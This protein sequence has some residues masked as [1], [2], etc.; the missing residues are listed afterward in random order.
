MTTIDI[1]TI[2][3]TFGYDDNNNFNNNN[4]NQFYMRSSSNTAYMLLYRKIDPSRNIS[5]VTLKE[6]DD[7]TTASSSFNG[8]PGNIGIV[9]TTETPELQVTQFY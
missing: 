2:S 6:D 9:D 7:L 5:N 8:N 4:N 1:N 3:N